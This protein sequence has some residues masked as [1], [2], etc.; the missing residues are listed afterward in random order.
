MTR[1]K[2]DEEA[3]FEPIKRTDDYLKIKVGDTKL[4]ILTSPIKGFEY[5]NAENKPVRSRERIAD[6]DMVNPKQGAKVKEFRAVWAFDYTD[7]KLKVWSF[8]QNSIKQQL[9]DLSKD[10]DFGDPKEYDVKITRSG[11]D[12]KTTYMVK[13]MSK[14]DFPL[15]PELSKQ[16]LEID[17]DKLFDNGHPLSSDLL[18]F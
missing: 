7:N 8:T 6:K 18:P 1:I 4:R 16:L 11:E 15:T 14:K 17:L 9:R 5:F 12:L 2:P 3:L 10:E 13:A